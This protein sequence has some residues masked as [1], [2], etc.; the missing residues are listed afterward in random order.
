MRS[1]LG[2]DYAQIGY[3]LALPAILAAAFEPAF[4][5]LADAG[6]RRA[7]VVAG[8]LAFAAGLGMIALAPGFGW[9][10]AGSIVLFPASGAFVAL[11]QAMLMDQDPERHEVNMARWTLAG[12][13]GAVLGPLILTA[14]VALG[15]GWRALVAGLALLTLPLVAG[16]RGTEPGRA[17]HESF[18]AAALGA[19]R[20]LRRGEVIRWLV[21]AEATNLMGDIL[22]GYLALYFVDEAGLSPVAA[23]GAIVI[24]TVAGLIGDAL[25]LVVLPRASGFHVLRVT[26]VLALALY[27][28]FLLVP[29]ARVKVALL[30]LIAL[31][32]AGWYAIPQG[33]L[34]TELGDESG[35]AVALSSVGGAIGGVVALVIGMLAE[36]A[37]LQA[38]LWI[39][40]LA[41]VALLALVTRASGRE[42]DVGA[43]DRTS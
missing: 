7:I 43:P 32:H 22:L 27:P 10:L 18:R 33:R 40:M 2:L 1:D 36:R 29:D 15:L 4:G 11:S 31:V 6:H 5:L 19:L 9:L 42:A 20:A 14:G 28:A 3:L 30:A 8:G 38:A 34:F 25:L 16:A 35:T 23:G 39:A 13:A 21:V 12:A 24:W 37:G 26:A 41:P 17:A